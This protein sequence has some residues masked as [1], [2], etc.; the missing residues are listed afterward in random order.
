[1]FG[2]LVLVMDLIVA[3]GLKETRNLKRNDSN[4]K[5]QEGSIAAAKNS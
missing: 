2:G 1:M 3:I 5:I 4:S